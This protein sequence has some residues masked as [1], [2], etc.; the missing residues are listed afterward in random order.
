MSPSTRN[1]RSSACGGE[2]PGVFGRREENL[3]FLS[4]WCTVGGGVPPRT[5]SPDSYLT[6]ELLT[7][8]L[9]VTSPPSTYP[10]QLGSHLGSRTSELQ[11]SR[12]SHVQT[13]RVYRVGG[14][15]FALRDLGKSGKASLG[16]GTLIKDQFD[17]GDCGPVSPW[18]S[19]GSL[20]V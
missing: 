1:A 5:P 9:R 12:I 2:D 16:F 11:V 4:A 7:N 8:Y 17:P 18:T 14:S 20:G 15:T 13:T 6:C 10:Y 19:Y 3:T